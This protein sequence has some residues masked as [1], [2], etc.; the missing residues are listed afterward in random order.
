M[1]K[2][3]Y[4]SKVFIHLVMI[5]LSAACLIPFILIISASFTGET[6]LKVDGYSLIP[7]EFS[8]E[9]YK[10]IF[11]SPHDIISAYGVTIFITVFGTIFGTLFMTMLAYPLSREDYK[12]KNIFSFYIYFTMLFSGGL[13]PTYLLVAKYLKL[14]DTVW[15]LIFPILMSGWNVFLLRMFL[16]SI[17]ISL[18]EAANL[19]G[20]SEFKIFFK[21]IIPLGKV[22][23]VTV[24]LFTALNYWN[25]WYQ[26]MLYI[27]NGD[28][29]SLQYLL[30]RVM[31]KVN[32]AKEYAG[33]SANLEKLPDEN[34]RMALCVIAAGPMLVVFPF[35][36]KYF[37]KGIIVGSVKG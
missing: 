1:K 34:L 37:S 27:D 21:I 31:N 9:A 10:Y 30:Y 19:E 6:A 2:N 7:S 18:I 23:I 14:K 36:Q 16:K 3:N 32:L 33:T 15:A 35:F 22:G 25:D 13:V 12:Y 20:A 8:L 5:L 28:I 4:C 29:T 24:A 26:S 17:P 11:A